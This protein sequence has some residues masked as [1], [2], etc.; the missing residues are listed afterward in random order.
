MTAFL[1]GDVNARIGGGCEIIKSVDDVPDR[2]VIDTTQ[3]KH[4][5]AYIDFLVEARMAVINGR[6]PG[7][8][9]FTSISSKGKAVVDYFAV[10][11]ENFGNCVKFEVHTVSEVI[12][13]NGLQP[14]LSEKCKASDHSIVTLTYAFNQ[15]YSDTVVDDSEIQAQPINVKRRYNYGTMSQDFLNSPTWAH[16]LDSLLSRIDRIEKVQSSVDDFYNDM[17]KSIFTEMDQHIDYRDASKRSRKQ[18]KNHKPFWNSDLSSAWKLMSDSEKVF[19]NANKFNRRELHNNYIFQRKSFD[20]LLRKTERSYFRNKA[21]EIENINTSNPTEFWQYIKSLGP[22]RKSAI[23]MQVYN[24]DGSKTD[25]CDSVMDKWK[26]EFRNL[27]NMPDDIDSAFDSE[28][29]ENIS[30]GLPNLKDFELNNNLANDY[31][32][33]KPF[34]INDIEKVCRKLKHGKSV[35]PDMLANEVLKHEGLRNLLLEFVNMCF[36]YNV[37]PSVWRESI[38]SPIPKSSTKDPCVPLNY[39]GISLLS[40]IYKLYTSLLNLR[41]TNHCEHND[42]LVDEQNGFRAKRSCQ[43]HIYALSTVIRNRRSLNL[44]TFCAFVDFKKAFDWVPRDLLLFK[45]ANSFGIHGRL[46]NTLSTIYESSSAKIRLNGLMTESFNVTS[47][48]KQGDIISPILFS[49]YLNDLATGIKNLNCGIDINGFNLAILL[50]ADD[51]V[52]ITPDEQSLQAMISFVADWCRKWRMA[53]NADKTQVVH[54][55][56]EK[57]DK[58]DY[59]F[60]MGECELQVVS[61]YKYLGV[62][63]DEY[64]LFDTNAST[65]AD[66]AIR[67]LGK[68]RSKLKTL[69]EC[70]VNSFNTLFKSGVL[71]IADYGA[72][73][74]GT[75]IYS[76]TE[77]VS[78]RAARY[79]LG[80]H[81]FAPIEALLGDMGWVAAKTRH[82]LLAISYWNRLC[83]LNS[84]RL[85]RRVFDWDRSFSNKKGTWSYFVKNVISDVGCSDSF[86]FAL[87]C[88]INLAET[89]LKDIDLTNWDINRYKSEKLRYYNLYKYDKYTEDFLHLNITRYQRSLL[90]QFRCGILPLE[91]EVGRYRNIKLHERIC[92]ICNTSVEDEI[93]FLCECEQ[94]SDLRI[95]LFQSALEVDSMFEHKDNLDKFVCLMSNCQKTVSTF[96]LKAVQRRRNIMYVNST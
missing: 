70:G 41:I 9:N 68:I 29:Y 11:I 93:H 78:Y 77:Q 57:A 47:G 17:L 33:N 15:Q 60:L 8:D 56:P 34:D 53:V 58:T 12:E 62:T 24:S 86:D 95:S 10:P 45:L 49:M 61:S 40:C 31:Y 84:E 51:I 19:L 63:F 44:D 36:V 54:F 74:W 88:D 35:G 46:F 30:A 89:V 69:K 28:F 22:K 13:K 37:I 5:D 80:V 3:N 55:R 67:A 42:L 2:K 23:P 85:T 1:C 72:G 38:I 52:L 83:N 94:Y 18:Y 26:S 79:F 39:R 50:Y 25:D 81:R 6:T 20:K 66:A 92:R 21:L 16:V 73:I 75:K 71:T 48:V 87:E 82:K 7:V 65:L 27:Y 76:K 59:C 90:A 91:I 96:L 32:Y 64:L 43:D 14:L 4:G